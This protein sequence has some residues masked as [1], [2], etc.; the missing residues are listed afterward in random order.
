MKQ[1]DRVVRL[2]R[3]SDPGDGEATDDVLIAALGRF[4]R[5]RAGQSVRD[6]L[7]S[8]RIQLPTAQ[9]VLRVNQD[10]VDD[11]DRTLRVGDRVTLVNRVR[12]G[13]FKPARVW[14]R[15]YA[16]SIPTRAAL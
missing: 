2:D 10:Q 7:V 14:V 11:L 15:L 12:G 1:Q 13:S 3:T 16:C 6:A 8:A 4:H 9:Q 5:A